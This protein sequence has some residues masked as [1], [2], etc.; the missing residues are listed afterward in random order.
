M[1]LAMTLKTRMVQAQFLEVLD[2]F[3]LFQFAVKNC[4]LGVIGG[5]LA[6][7]KGVEFWRE[8]DPGW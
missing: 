5:D 3:K 1:D 2:F 8:V 4:I 7:F 6:H